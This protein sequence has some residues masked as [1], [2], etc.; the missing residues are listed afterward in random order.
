MPKYTSP[1]LFFLLITLFLAQNQSRGQQLILGAGITPFSPVYSFSSLRLKAAVTNVVNRFG[2]YGM[3]ELNP[4]N[5]YGRDAI[6]I[7]YQVSCL[8]RVWAGIGVFED[9]L[10]NPQNKV[11]IWNGIRK[12]MGIGYISRFRPI[13]WELGY[14]FTLGPTFQFYYEIPIVKK[15]RNGDGIYNNVDRSIPCVLEW[16]RR[17]STV[18]IVNDTIWIDPP[19]NMA[20]CEYPLPIDSFTEI[21]AT[22]AVFE[23][24]LAYEKDQVKL[25]SNMVETLRYYVVGILKD[26]TDYFIEI[27]SHVACDGQEEYNLQLTQRR[28]DTLK[29]HLVDVYGLNPSRVRSRGFGETTPANHCH[30]EGSDVVGFTPYIDSLTYKRIP[31]FDR[32]GKLLG[33][34]RQ[35]YEAKEI[36]TI[37]GIAYVKCDYYQRDQNNRI[38]IRFKKKEKFYDRIVDTCHRI[39]APKLKNCRDAFEKGSV[40][41]VKLSSNSF[42]EGIYDLPLSFEGTS[43]ALNYTNKK[44]LDSFAINFLIPNPTLVFEIGAHT[45]CRQN[46]INNQRI[47]NDRALRIKE[48][49]VETHKIDS[50]RIEC[51]GYGEEKLIND[52]K[53]E[54]AEINAYT[55]FIQGKTKKLE[56]EFDA[57][58]NISGSTYA[59]YLQREIKEID[60]N[61]FVPCNDRQHRQNNRITLR[62]DTSFYAICIE[63]EYTPRVELEEPDEEDF[64]LADGIDFNN[65]DITKAFDEIFTLPIFYDLD[66][67]A[68]RPDAQRILDTFAVKILL[69]YPELITELGSHTDCRMPY[70]Y[71]ERLAQRRADSAVAYLIKRWN[72]S[73]NRIIAKGYGEKQLVNECHCE[74]KMAVEYTPYIP[75][76]TRKMLVDLDDDGNV[77][78]TLYAEYDPKEIVYFG[79]MGF[80]KCE[81]FQHR[82]NRRT[83]VRFT[84]DPAK[85]GI[86]VDVDRDAN[87]T[88]IS[89]SQYYERLKRGGLGHIREVVDEFQNNYTDIK[90]FKESEALQKA[91]ALPIF[92]DL[93]KA[94]IRPDAQKVLDEFAENILLKY[95]KLIA[96]LGSH[97]DCRMPYDYNVRLSKRRADSAVAYL[98]QRWNI[99]SNRV[100]AVGY[101]E[102]QKI[103]ACACEGNDATEFT[104]FVAGLTQKMLVDLD[105]DGNV[106]TSF[107]SDY[108]PNEI[109]YIEGKPF[110]KCEEFQHRQN[111][112]TTVRF[113]NDP[114]DFGLE[115]DVDVDKNNVNQR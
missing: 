11:N 61:P 64:I 106:I 103:N 3:W 92:Y 19:P 26:H 65:F 56:V 107:Y 12:E 55:P 98:I 79:D 38:T 113:A 95:P 24:P 93:D 72:I 17:D 66:K 47:S 94:V 32:S 73:P 115:I 48:Y 99:P 82:Q 25:N 27:G 15:D 102:H 104:P 14:S 13:Q 68:I 6:G 40:P 49:L 45:D 77:I 35:A 89:Q 97:T 84:N 86:K 33:F 41:Y 101:G 59:D 34:I 78:G 2:M 52:C 31:N 96:E 1:K 20:N 21:N 5:S 67:S 71:N 29:N 114:R 42:R 37:G 58:G 60:G 4:Y 62:I 7:N 91:Y 39:E 50:N 54:G 85:F 44:V 18:E 57:R 30:C 53:C 70:S 36:D 10:I 51:H 9:G 87:N 111:R 108:Q 16:Q 63:K 8:F 80:V 109:S 23:L 83:T 112:R 43:T 22:S 105:D 28:A 69:K 88:N 75:G 100:V 90:N 110:V 74:D 76:R 81:E 46:K